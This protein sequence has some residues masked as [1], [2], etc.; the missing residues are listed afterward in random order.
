MNIK[1]T[2]NAE[3]KTLVIE[4]RE[5]STHFKEFPESVLVAME[6]ISREIQGFIL[7]VGIKEGK[8]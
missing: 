2:I 4:R 6:E 1:I 3:N 8:K 7:D 5:I